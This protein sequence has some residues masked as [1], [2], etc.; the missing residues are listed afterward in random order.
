MLPERKHVV[1]HIRSWKVPQT[2]IFPQNCFSW[3]SSSQQLSPFFRL[4]RVNN[5]GLPCLLFFLFKYHMWN[6]L[7]NFMGPGYRNEIA[8]H[9]F[10][11]QG[12]GII[13]VTFL[14]QLFSKG[15]RHTLEGSPRPLS[16]DS[17]CQNYFP[18]N[19]KTLKFLMFSYLQHDLNSN[20]TSSSILS[21][22]IYT[23]NT[24]EWH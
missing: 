10:I 6:P 9:L 19:T 22:R 14:D 16:G 2:K 11:F 24:I 20:S 8:Y 13:I 5:L 23:I 15:G 12:E 1:V 18:L 21:H 3:H 4:L 17:W 7:I